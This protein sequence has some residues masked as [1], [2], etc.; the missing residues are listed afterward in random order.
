MKL[1][2]F[3]LVAAAAAAS[4]DCTVTNFATVTASVPVYAAHH[5]GAIENTYTA[6]TAVTPTFNATPT[7]EVFIPLGS[8][9]DAVGFNLGFSSV[10]TGLSLD[11]KSIALFAGDLGD[12]AQM[13]PDVYTVYQGDMEFIGLSADPL[14]KYTITGEISDMNLPSY[15]VEFNV[16]INNQK[17]ISPVF[18][19]RDL[20]QIVLKVVIVNPNYNDGSSSSAAGSTSGSSTGTSTGTSTGSTSGT[21]S[22]TSTGSSSGSEGSDSTLTSVVTPTIT[23]GNEINN[24]H[25][26]YSTVRKTITSCSDHKC[27]T[28]VK[29]A[30]VTTVPVT[31]DDV[32]TYYVTTC[33][34]DELSSLEASQAA[35]ATTTIPKAV[36]PFYTIT[37]ESVSSAEITTAAAVTTAKIVKS[38]ETVSASVTSTA[39]H[40]SVV[41]PSVEFNA[42]GKVATSGSLLGFV[43][44]ALLLI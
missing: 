3:S 23:T 5:T 43:F 14:L 8:Y 22:G 7:F 20:E 38:S 27:S 29:D 15:S 28:I 42:A 10:S 31:I 44:G 34:L 17:K 1:A 21:T 26:V 40:S 33:P 30:I 25:T 32:T 9:P 24:T 39:A 36:E 11:P 41:Y 19:K 13:N 6:V 2:L 4:A 35:K 37:S 12:F 16:A 18:S